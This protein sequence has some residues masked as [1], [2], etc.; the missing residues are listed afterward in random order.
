MISLSGCSKHS[1]V[2]QQ[3]NINFYHNQCAEL[4]RYIEICSLL[5]ICLHSIKTDVA[6]LNLLLASSMKQS[7][8]HFQYY[9]AHKMVLNFYTF[10]YCLKYSA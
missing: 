7:S 5:F 3:G 2:L 8:V 6:G 4:V 1:S 10:I 9:N